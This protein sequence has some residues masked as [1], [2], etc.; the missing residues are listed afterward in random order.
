M[1]KTITVIGNGVRFPVEVER[2]PG[3]IVVRVDG[4]RFEV[5]VRERTAARGRE[6]IGLRPAPSGHRTDAAGAGRAARVDSRGQCCRG[7]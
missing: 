6:P 5:A 7:R 4:D 2:L 3:S 1:V